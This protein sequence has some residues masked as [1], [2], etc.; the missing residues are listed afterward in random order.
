MWIVTLI[1]S[2]TPNHFPAGYFPRKLH[3]KSEAK[4]LQAE[5]ERNGG[6]ATVTKGR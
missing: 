5:V 1:V 6:Q 2:P 4:A 3:Y